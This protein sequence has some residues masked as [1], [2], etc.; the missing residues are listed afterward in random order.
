VLQHG[1]LPKAKDCK[2]NRHQFRIR[3]QT[4]Q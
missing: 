1:V 4:C 2:S 3:F